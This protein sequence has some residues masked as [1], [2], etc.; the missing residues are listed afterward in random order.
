MNDIKF[1]KT[2]GGLGRQGLSE[3]AV[4]GLLMY[5]PSFPL[6]T[7]VNASH[8]KIWDIVSM[9]SGDVLYVTKFTYPEQLA[10]CG[11]E[12]LAMDVETLSAITSVS[13]TKIK[14]RSSVNALHYH[15]TEFFRM[16]PGGV[17]Y[18]G[19]P[20]F[21]SAT[22]LTAE[23]VEAMQVYA[24]GSIRQ[25]ALL[26]NGTTV[27]A[28]MQTEAE[29]LERSH[30]PLSLLF[31]TPGKTCVYSANTQS[32]WLPAYTAVSALTL[33]K[34]KSST[35]SDTFIAAGRSN[36]S[37]IAACDVDPQQI[38]DL[39]HYAYAGT[40]GAALGAL[41]RAAVNESIAWVGKFP[42]GLSKPGLISGE[43]INAVAIA[44][45]DAVNA[46]RYVFVR[47]F[48][49]DA[50][51]YFNDSFTLD[52]ETSDYAFIEN[53]RT[54]DKMCREVFARLL[55]WLNS[56]VKVDASTGKLDGGFCSFLETT[57]G[58]AIED[59]EKAGEISG[60]SVAIDPDQNVLS[61]SVVEVVIRSVPTG[62]MRKVNVKIGFT[63]KI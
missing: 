40:V 14:E 5:L 55:P 11:I 24:G 43:S 49:G 9:E 23:C 38:E 29:A 12:K 4:S 54:I 22:E 32:K 21:D 37:F 34:L 33:A 50:G 42:V 3:D 58:S 57:A 39:G 30:M 36:V 17:L 41:S 31:T 48:N 13:D 46:N 44:D 1:E 19:L 56:P 60:Y 27:I 2:K 15:V 51:N 53:E 61:T 6:S 26:A 59:M 47:T 35:A 62:T 20:S 52:V 10:D 45:L 7:L 28:G 16:N 63:T 25:M 8:A 18:V